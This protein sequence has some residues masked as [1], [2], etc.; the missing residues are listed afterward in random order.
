[1]TNNENNF[2]KGGRALKFQAARV[3]LVEK[4][5]AHGIF[6]ARGQPDA[7]EMMAAPDALNPNGR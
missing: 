4:F 6:I 5:A 3:D 1:M 2:N 7:S